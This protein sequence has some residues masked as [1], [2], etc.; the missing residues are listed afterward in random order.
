MSLEAIIGRLGNDPR[1]VGTFFDFDGVLAPLQ[2]DPDT[3][4]PLD[5]ATEA[6]SALAGTVGIVGVVSGR[7]VSFL[8][9]FFDDERIELS[10]LYGIEHRSGGDLTV[11]AAAAEWGPMMA[12]TV[13]E[14]T[15]EFGSDAV[16]DKRYSITVHYRRQ[17]AAFGER[18]HAWASDLA[19]RS[20]LEARPAKMSV[21]LHPPSSRSKGDA[22][23]DML[24]GMRAGSYFGD[25]VGDLPGF[26]RLATLVD[27]GDLDESARIL[28]AGPETPDELRAHVTDI[29]DGPT[30]ALEAIRHMVDAAVG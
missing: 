8:E 28:V 12:T 2:D 25:D 13:Q 14:A 29:V 9:R 16:E 22:I 26:S 18:V 21:E 15:R 4:R 24:A 30:G 23:E 5:G 17:D 6:L 10:G 20:G 1:S 7:P 11:D 3:V 19:V 27:R